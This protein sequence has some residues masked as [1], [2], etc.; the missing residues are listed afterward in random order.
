MKPF[1]YGGVVSGDFFCPRQK[2]VKVLRTY[3]ENC[4]NAV[5]FGARRTGKTSLMRDTTRKMKGVR[6]LYAD[7]LNALDYTGRVSGDVQ[8]LGDSL[9]E[10]E[11]GFFNPFFRD[12]LLR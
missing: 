6:V 4:Q 11:Y 9:C 10:H 12:W 2:L 8:E 7:L 3:V 1:R 5:I